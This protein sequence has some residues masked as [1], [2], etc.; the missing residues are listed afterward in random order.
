MWNN[1]NF[2][3]RSISKDGYRSECTTCAKKVYMQNRSERLEGQKIYQSD[4]RDKRNECFRKRRERG[5]NF[6]LDHNLRTRRSHVFDAQNAGKVNKTFDVL[7][8]SH[9]FIEK[10]NNSSTLW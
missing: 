5:L 3:K 2:L 7:D 8:C 4:K 10:M 6:K 1:F 9:T